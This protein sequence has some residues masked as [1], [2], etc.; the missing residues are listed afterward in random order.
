LRAFDVPKINGFLRYHELPGAEPVRLY[1]HGIALSSASFVHVSAHP[2]L[3]GQRSLLVDFLGFGL[4]D[5]P[6]SFG[7]A[8]EEHA[9]VVAQLLDAL[10]VRECQVV[11]HSMG[12]A[13]ATIL[14][15]RRPDLI[16]ALVLAESNLVAGAGF[17]TRRIVAATEEEYVEQQWAED[18]AMFREGAPTDDVLAAVLGMFEAAAP[19]AMHR[20]AVSLTREREPSYVDILVSLDARRTFLVGSKTLEAPEPPPSGD[21]GAPLRG[22]DVPVVPV[23]E[24][25]HAMMF[26]NP[27]G[28]ANAVAAALV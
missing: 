19:W 23:P 12:G 16:S 21:D 1:L 8:M 6:Q 3:A 27:D 11:A 22:T 5:R 9:E 7:Y 2:A 24:A 18:I 15:Q 14:A 13:V 17:F 20:S 10:S 28:F 4:S 26:H 25:G